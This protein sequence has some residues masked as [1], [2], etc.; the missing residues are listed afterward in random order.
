MLPYKKPTTACSVL[1]NESGMENSRQ[2]EV[3]PTQTKQFVS[4][5]NQ[6]PQC[7][8]MGGC[9]EADMKMTHT[10]THGYENIVFL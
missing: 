1:S 2:R 7:N 5:T 3:T 8:K 9:I 6:C 4:Y 10:R